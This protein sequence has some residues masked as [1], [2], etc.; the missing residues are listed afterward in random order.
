MQT[1]PLGKRIG[2]FFR[3]LSPLRCNI[4]LSKTSGLVLDLRLE[5]ILRDTSGV[6][7]LGSATRFQFINSLCFRNLYEIVLAILS[8]IGKKI[9]EVIK[10]L[11]RGSKTMTVNHTLMV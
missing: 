8:S 4:D 11:T 7:A 1:C 9:A 5:H 3:N 10:P 2:W 6:V